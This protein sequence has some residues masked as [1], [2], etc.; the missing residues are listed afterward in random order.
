[1]YN[2]FCSDYKYASVCDYV[3]DIQ[4]T[5]VHPICEKIL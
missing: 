1:M 5:D 2:T 4:K 3:K